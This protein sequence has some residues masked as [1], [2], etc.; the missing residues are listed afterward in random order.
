V[1]ELVQYLLKVSKALSNITHLSSPTGTL[2]LSAVLCSLV[3][4]SG[5]SKSKRQR[6]NGHLL[7]P[8]LRKVLPTQNERLSVMWAECG[9]ISHAM[10]EQNGK[11]LQKASRE[12]G[13]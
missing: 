8:S 5:G 2:T 12:A 7:P 13:F 11:M 10:C 3:R 4:G 9:S 6:V 1:K